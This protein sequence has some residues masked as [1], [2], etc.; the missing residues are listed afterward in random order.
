MVIVN[1]RKR[2]MRAMGVTMG[3]ALVAMQAA[4]ADADTRKSCEVH[5]VVMVAEMKA[6]AATPMNDE[7]VA[8]VR[9]TALK[10]CL[11]QSGAGTSP[12]SAVAAAPAVVAQVSAPATAAQAKPD[13]S[14]FGTLGQIFSGPVVRK[15]GNERLLERSQH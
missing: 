2:R 6:S 11:V 8:L 3:L 12:A 1:A 5:A 15:P 4:V 10:S 13:N 14:F 9:A 7:Q